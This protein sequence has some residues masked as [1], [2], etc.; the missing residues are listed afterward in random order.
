MPGQKS[1]GDILTAINGSSTAF[2][3]L[4]PGAIVGSSS[5]NPAAGK[6]FLTSAASNYPACITGGSIRSEG[7]ANVAGDLSVSGG[8]SFG[9]LTLSDPTTFATSISFEINIPN[10]IRGIISIQFFV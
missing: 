2:G 6:Y 8:L 9:S 3:Y 10:V 1:L 5:F 4:T 7:D